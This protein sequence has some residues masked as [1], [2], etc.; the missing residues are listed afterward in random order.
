MSAYPERT[1]TTC[2]YCG[3]GCQQ[4]LHVHEGKIVEVTG[5]EDAEPNQGRL[6][7]KGRYGY[8]F[9]YSDERVKIR[10]ALRTP[11]PFQGGNI[12]YLLTYGSIDIY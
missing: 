4:W 8:D 3:G 6:G 2:P 7:V 5:V 11:D 12:I 1:R 10:I 9:I